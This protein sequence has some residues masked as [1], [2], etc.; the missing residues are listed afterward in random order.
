MT[1][2][3]EVT[4]MRKM[5][6][7]IS[8][9]NLFLSLLSIVLGSL[10][11]GFYKGQMLRLGSDYAIRMKGIWAWVSESLS[12]YFAIAFVAFLIVFFIV[13]MLHKNKKE[14]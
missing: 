3:S 8:V 1:C 12:I 10:M 11:Q 5:L 4:I 7:T 14:N 13:F 6:L 2:E 9:Y